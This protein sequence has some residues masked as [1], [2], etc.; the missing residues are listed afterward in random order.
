MSTDTEQ[1]LLLRFREAAALE[2]R[3]LWIEDF[4]A[5]RPKTEDA[6]ACRRRWAVA[7]L[8]FMQLIRA[9]SAI[10]PFIETIREHLLAVHEGRAQ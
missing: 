7:T 3:L 6:L 5:S 10:A 1:D 4:V 9:N 8:R 2:H